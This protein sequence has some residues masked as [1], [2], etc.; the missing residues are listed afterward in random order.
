MLTTR[1]RYYYG[2][3]EESDDME[4]NMAMDVPIEEDYEQDLVEASNDIDG[5][6]LDP[7]MVRKA[8]ALEMNE[9]YRNVYEQRSIEECFEK[10][11][12]LLKKEKWNNT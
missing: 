7:E 5:Q 2:S 1:R 12:T 11:E 8:R 6:E 3:V 10:T 4:A 9:W